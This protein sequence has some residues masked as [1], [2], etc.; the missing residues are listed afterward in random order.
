MNRLSLCTP[1]TELYH[2]ILTFFQED[3]SINV[4]QSEDEYRIKMYVEDANKAEALAA[5]IP[6]VKVIGNLVINIDVIP[7]NGATLK[8]S[9]ADSGVNVFKRAFKGNP[10]ISNY[11]HLEGMGMS[12]DY[13][14]CAPKVVRMNN[15]SLKNPWGDVATLYEYIADEIFANHPGVFF[16]TDRWVG[17]TEANP[18]L[19][20]KVKFPKDEM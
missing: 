19:T 8:S 16:T 14:L 17:E 4:V 15:D 10:A 12:I 13:I 9:V 18:E 3:K 1:Y 6:T 20:R 5:I 2:Q 11:M 7:A